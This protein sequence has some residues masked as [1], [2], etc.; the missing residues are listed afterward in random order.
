[1]QAP[2]ILILELC[3]EEQGQI[4][5]SHKWEISQVLFF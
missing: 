5:L 2:T 4:C 3:V 1:M